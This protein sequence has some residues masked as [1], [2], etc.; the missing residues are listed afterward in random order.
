[1]PPVRI[2]G[3]PETD[4]VRFVGR[5]AILE[6][7]RK[8]A[9]AVATLGF[10]AIVYYSPQYFARELRFCARG[11]FVKVVLPWGVSPEQ[12][13]KGD[14]IARKLKDLKLKHW[15]PD[16]PIDSDAITPTA[17]N[18]MKYFFEND[19]SLAENLKKQIE[20]DHLLEKHIEP[21]GQERSRLEGRFKYKICPQDLEVW[22]SSQE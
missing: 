14:R 19:L 5:D 16:T 13:E 4:H 12:K 18:W 9:F 10:A 20:Q 8:V 7:L 21:S 22:I 3:L 11:P 15:E 17:D 6:W 2:T 1:V